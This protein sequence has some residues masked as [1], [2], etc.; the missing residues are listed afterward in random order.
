MDKGWMP[1]STTAWVWDTIRGGGA[2]SL[3][4]VVSWTRRVFGPAFFQN[5]HL[6]NL[7]YMDRLLDSFCHGGCKGKFGCGPTCEHREV[8]KGAVDPQ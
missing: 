8:C 5:G 2:G 7:V 6:L 1:G 4:I 3:N